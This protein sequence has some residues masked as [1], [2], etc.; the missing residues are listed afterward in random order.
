MDFSKYYEHLVWVTA[1]VA[2]FFWGLIYILF[3]SL[4]GMPEM[5]DQQ[6][7]LFIAW[8]FG[9]HNEPMPLWQGVLFAMFDAGILG[10]VIGW[11]LRRIFVGKKK[12]VD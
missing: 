1:L 7:T 3:A 4:H 10:G 6:F 5:F 9:I 11:L 12:Q 8:L 2:A